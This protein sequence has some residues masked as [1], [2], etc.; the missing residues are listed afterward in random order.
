[1]VIS[2][3][4][5]DLLTDAMARLLEE[6]LPPEEHVPVDLARELQ[7]SYGRLERKARSCNAVLDARDRLPMV[8]ADPATMRLLIDMLLENALDNLSAS[9]GEGSAPT[10]TV[11][12]RRDGGLHQ[13]SVM[14]NGRPLDEEALKKLFF[15]FGRGT[16]W[17]GVESPAMG[18]GMA[19]ARKIAQQHGGRM[20]SELTSQGE[21]VISFTIP[22]HSSE[23]KSETADEP[24]KSE[25]DDRNPM[26]GA[27]GHDGGEA[28]TDSGVGGETY[29]ETEAPMGDSPPSDE[30]KASLHRDQATG[31]DGPKDDGPP[32][33]NGEPGGGGG[34]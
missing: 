9:Q 5:V 25:D 14:D 28:T 10:I 32:H 26:W 31:G 1:L 16:P 7:N 11:T 20:W 33:G 15:P 22:V 17:R 19:L 23:R 12:C 21:N 18:L 3:R 34:D 30:L 6:P 24:R 29:D 4:R 27:L 2:A 8:R 13:I